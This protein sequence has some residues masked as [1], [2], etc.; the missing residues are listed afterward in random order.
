MTLFWPFPTITIASGGGYLADRGAGHT[1]RFHQGIDDPVRSGT[2]ILAA[3]AGRVSAIINTG[4]TSGYGLYV[5]VEY[6]GVQVRYAHMSRVDVTVGQAVTANTRL[7]LSGGI[8]HT[9]GAGDATGPH[10]HVEAH[11]G[12]ALVNPLSYLADRTGTSGGGATP[13]DDEEIETVKSYH[14]EDKTARAKGR[15]LAPGLGF[16]LS[17]TLDAPVSSASNVV[18]GIGTYSLTP[19]VYAAGLPG[20]AVDLVLIWEATKRVP[21]TTSAHYIEHLVF[22]ADGQIKASREFKRGVASGDAVFVR[23]DA[24]LTNKGP[25]KVTLLDCDAF[26]FLTS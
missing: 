22:D 23:L 12:A 25:L 2:V 13:I 7:G 17:T 15:T 16:Y 10:C 3:G 9:F 14:N 24:P 18:G 6:A 20:D 26:L 11:V 1:P 4:T 8:R 21:P 19:H 5:Q